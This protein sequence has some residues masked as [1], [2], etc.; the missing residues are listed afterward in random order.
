MW[1][2]FLNSVGAAKRQLA[3]QEAIRIASHVAT[4][5]ACVHSMGAILLVDEAVAVEPGRA[6]LRRY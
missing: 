6:R 1:F 4:A 3:I 2:R 5:L